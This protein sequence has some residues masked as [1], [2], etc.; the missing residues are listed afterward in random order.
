MGKNK[1]FLNT[2]TGGMSATGSQNAC[3]LMCFFV[4]ENT[5]VLHFSYKKTQCFTSL[6]SSVLKTKRFWKYRVL[7][8]EKESIFAVKVVSIFMRMDQWKIMCWQ[9]IAKAH[10]T[11][12]KSNDGLTTTRFAYRDIYTFN[13]SF[14][15]NK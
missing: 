14:I 6:L 5:C 9:S 4:W 3:V 10:K 1:Y 8:L 7:K 12:Q 2:F 13:N 15:L 11:D